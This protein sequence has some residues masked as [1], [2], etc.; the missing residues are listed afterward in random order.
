MKT[1]EHPKQ[2]CNTKNPLAQGLHRRRAV[3]LILVIS[4]V[5][6]LSG[7]VVTFFSRVTTDLA[8]ARSYAEGVTVRQL[9]DSAVGVVMGQIRE[10]TSLKNACWASQPG[11]IRTYRTAGGQPG[12]NAYAFYKLYSSHDLIVSGRELAAFDPSVTSASGS[13]T[14]VE[15]PLGTGG[16]SQ[17]PAFFTDV[18]EPV[19]VPDPAGGANSKNTVKRYPVFDASV[20]AI[21]NPGGRPAKPNWKVEGSEVALSAADR[22]TN[23]APM[24]VRWIYVLKDGTLTVPAPLTQPASGTS[25]LVAIW[26]TAGTRKSKTGVP[27]RS[28][29]I[30]G[31]IAFWTDDDSCKVNINTAGGFLLPDGVDEDVNLNYTAAGGGQK[32]TNP[33]YYAGSFWDTPRVQTRF[34]RGINSGNADLYRGG[35]SNSQPAQNEFQRYPGHPSTTSLGLVFRY[36]LPPGSTGFNSEKLY[37]MTPRLMPGG[38]LNGTIYLNT[39]VDRPLE[40]KTSYEGA[41][42]K[43]KSY[44]LFASIDE[45]FYSAKNGPR[46]SAVDG[47]NAW[48]QTQDG[49]APMKTD[50]ITTRLVDQ[51]RF[52]L[53]ANNRSPELNLFGRPRVTMWPVPTAANEQVLQRYGIR[54]VSDDLIR[55]CSTVGRD[56]NPTRQAITRQGEFI[57]DRQDPYSPAVDFNLPR[58]KQV[59]GYLREITSSAS[60]QIPGFG[61]S[62]EQKYAG[63]PGGRD[64]I[65]TEIFDYIRTIN[66][67]DNSRDRAIDHDVGLA[68][69]SAENNRLKAAARYAPHAL[70][71]PTRVTID[72]RQVSG[73]GRYPTISEAT[74]VFYHAGYTCVPKEGSELAKED[75]PAGGSARVAGNNAE[76]VIYDVSKTPGDVDPANPAN[77]AN[78][79]NAAANKDLTSPWAKA[80]VEK[81]TGQLIRAFL[82]FETFNPM[83]GY[84]PYD[85]FARIGLA[86]TTRTGVDGKFVRYNYTDPIKGVFVHELKLSGQ[87][88]IQSAGSGGA[89]PLKLGD[90]TNLKNSFTRTSGETWAGRNFGGTE[91]FFHTMLDHYSGNANAA[92]YY[93]FQSRCT[94]P[95]KDGILVG[96][97]DKNFDFIGGKADLL[98]GYEDAKG[99]KEQIQKISLDF[100]NASSWPMPVPWFRPDTGGFD[101]RVPGFDADSPPFAPTSPTTKWSTWTKSN[102]GLPAGWAMAYNLPSRISWTTHHSYSPYG[103]INTTTGAITGDGHHY[104]NRFLQ[105]LQPGDTIRSLVIGGGDPEASD[106]RVASLQHEVQTVKAHP[107]YF[108]AT[109]RRAETLRRADGGFYFDPTALYNKIAIYA[110]PPSSSSEAT[111]GSFIPLGNMKYRPSFGPDLVRKDSKGQPFVARRSDGQLADFDT[112]LGFFPDGAYAGKADEGNVAAYWYDE[113][114][115]TWHY[116]EPYFTWVYDLPLDTYFSPNRQVPGPVM[117]G[118]LPAPHVPWAQAGWKTLLFCPNAA[119][120]NHPGAQ[121]PPDHLLLDLF[122]MPVVEPYAISEP[123]STA[124]K[125]NLNY[126]MVPFSYIKRTTALRAALHSLRV[127]AIPQNFTHGGNWLDYKGRQNN[128][129]LRYLVDRDET[130]KAFDAFFEQY[131]VNKN[132]GF[133]KSASQI[134]ERYLYPKGVVY[135][136]ASIKYATGEGAIRAF[137]NANQLT[138]DN[139]REKPYADLYPRI[140]TKSN[141]YTVHYR[142][143]T[144]RQRPY[145]GNANGSDAYYRTFDETRDK[146]LSEFRGHAT[147]ERYLDPEDPRFQSTY[148]PA[149]DRIDV[150]KGSL[151]E[152]YRFRIIRNTRFSPW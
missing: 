138:G 122:G 85:N 128:E 110:E 112:G 29:P 54:N 98:L 82:L 41:L 16:W 62:F 129:N 97:D 147:I 108:S 71:V 52:F 23:D 60:G 50:S 105:I 124:G 104:A 7:L 24:P 56:S 48:A 134:C 67:K 11:M 65:L 150:E 120:P 123:F 32:E 152:A 25:G 15:V 38:S 43:N 100:P 78:I 127:T 121:S 132:A 119:G 81:W 93:P 131:K 125:V 87:F 12:P 40:I 86:D 30:V 72:G 66:Q 49:E 83:Q 46:I 13:S 130:L 133:F 88:A 126:P 76:V 148:T 3:A 95:L 53:T 14:A 136:G 142:V 42:D 89:K 74:L 58:N 22:A 146:I 91:G 141:T 84:A 61:G 51:S 101:N 90:G 34:D 96:V 26:S 106:A 57:F 33:G 137:W 99:H 36:L 113:V 10:A 94:D 151:E 114:Y 8:A 107:D 39:V 92:N 44:H 75:L 59:F 64:Q 77:P 17:Q 21:Y 73:F 140:T 2:P 18:N 143:Q 109:K 144:L 28:N 37:A 47:I 149:R 116:V 35:L 115:G 135:G 103:P 6:L 5:V 55:F 145:T 69:G 68:P 20:A 4:F 111:T 139:V 118:S 80:N 9:A 19:E 117:F 31:R 45:L 70:V 102:R 1:P 63:G 27:T 79:A